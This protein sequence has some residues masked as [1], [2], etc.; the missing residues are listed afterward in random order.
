MQTQVLIIGGGVTGTALARDL[1]L[2]GVDCILVEKDDINAGA[3]GRNHGLLHSGARYVAGDRAAAMECRAEGD[4][5]QAHGGADDPGHR[6]L[7]R[8]GARRRRTLHR[9]LP[10]PLRARRNQRARSGRRRGTRAGTG[11][12]GTRDRGVRGARRGDRP[13]PAVPGIHGSRPQPGRAS[14]AAQPRGRLRARGPADPR[15]ARSVPR[16]RGG[17]AHRGRAS[18]QRR[19]RLGAGGGAARRSAAGDDAIPRARCW[20][21]TRAWPTAS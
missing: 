21:R 17:A 6:R 12:V 1:A 15:G 5:P 14:A 3:S 18:R 20:S 13:V 19:G 4:D 7:F 10:V 2:R 8:R 16:R 9:R 11:A